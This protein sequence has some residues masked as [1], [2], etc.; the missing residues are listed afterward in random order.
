MRAIIRSLDPD[1]GNCPELFQ[2]FLGF[3]KQHL[4]VTNRAHGSADQ[5]LE[6]LLILLNDRHYNDIMAGRC[7]AFNTEESVAPCKLLS[8]GDFTL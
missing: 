4:A 1:E 6:S 3:L 7:L 5:P 8:T 2:Q